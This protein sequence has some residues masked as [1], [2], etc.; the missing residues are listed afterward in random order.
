[1]F[2]KYMENFE[3]NK[4]FMETNFNFNKKQNPTTKF[5]LHYK[6]NFLFHSETEKSFV[7]Y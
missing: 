1:M 4:C 2:E 6:M 3:R 7:L 5:Q